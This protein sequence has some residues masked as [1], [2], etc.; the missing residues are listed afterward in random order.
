MFFFKKKPTKHMLELHWWP[1]PPC[2]VIT[3]A[4]AEFAPKII[5]LGLISE[6]EKAFMLPTDFTV[7]HNFLWVY[8]CPERL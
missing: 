7:K 2:C 3:Q 8:T 6:Q 4:L 5:I 1:D